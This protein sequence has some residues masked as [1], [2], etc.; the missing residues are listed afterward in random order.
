MKVLGVVQWATRDKGGSPIAGVRPIV[1]LQKADWRPIDPAEEFPS[2]GQVFWPNAQSA[3]EGA[4]VIFSAASNPGQKDE[5][6][7]VDAKPAYEV[8]DL[9]SIGKAADVRE[10]LVGGVHVPGPLGTVR[11]LVW[12]KDALV[13]P[14]ELTRVATGTVKLNGGNLAR[15]PSF[16][17]DATQ[18]RSVVVDKT[19]RWL[20]VDDGA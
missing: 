1:E 8:L 2:Q 11:V 18:V 14:V 5:F 6:K 17:C 10:A 7:A 16:A 15:V 3:A 19:T 12:C 13:G 4:L 9:R 20:R